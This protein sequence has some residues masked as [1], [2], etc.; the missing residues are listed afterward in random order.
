MPVMSGTSRRFTSSLR[1]RVGTSLQLRCVATIALFAATACASSSPSSATSNGPKPGPNLIT[2]D[3]IARVNV[4]NAF[5]AVQKLRPSMLRQRQIASANGQGGLAKDVPPATGTSVSA[6]QL[7]VY[8][9]NTRLGD[10]EQLRQIPASS[11]A[12]L[13]YYSASEAQ[14]KWGSGHP[15]GAIEVI[16][17]R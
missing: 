6:G 2:A 13:R 14:T 5:E 3:E 7:V 11:V 15:G 16:S 10:V 4:Q 8:M 17:K 9:D 12:A 1:F